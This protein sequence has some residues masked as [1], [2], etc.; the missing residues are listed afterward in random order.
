LLVLHVHSEEKRRKENRMRTQPELARPTP[1]AG[2]PPSASGALQPTH[3][4]IAARAYELYERRGDQNGSDV[5]DWL[6]A[7]S[8]LRDELRPQSVAV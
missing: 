4:E 5:Q 8:Q 1:I 2:E 7:E 6:S 3:D